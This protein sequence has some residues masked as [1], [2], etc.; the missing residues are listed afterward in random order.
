MPYRP[1]HPCARPGCPELITSD[2]RYC[3]EHERTLQRSYNAARP[4]ASRRG[5]GPS[6]RQL[7]LMFLRE[8]PLCACGAPA[9]EVD[10]I[11]PLA[12]G[13]TNEESNLQALCK[14]CHSAKTAREDGR[15][16]N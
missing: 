1:R 13:G 11:V 8:H 10:H 15:W 3:D 2:R 6:W 5:Y 14:A 9:T 16:G 7:R 4:S 12:R